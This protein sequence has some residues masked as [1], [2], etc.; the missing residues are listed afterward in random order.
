MHVEKKFMEVECNMLV[1]NDVRYKI[2]C[3]KKSHY[4]VVVQWL[5][6]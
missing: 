6:T 2:C 4:G 3:L 1:Q 5:R